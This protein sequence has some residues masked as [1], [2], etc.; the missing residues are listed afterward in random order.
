MA[1]KLISDAERAQLEEIV[2]KEMAG[3][4]LTQ[5]E[6]E[7]LKKNYREAFNIATENLM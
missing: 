1:K 7:L 5:E 2:R 6:N 3:Q 4:P